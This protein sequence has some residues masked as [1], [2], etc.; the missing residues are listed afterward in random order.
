MINSR[1]GRFKDHH[2]DNNDSAG[3]VD[4]FCS[5]PLTDRQ[6]LEGPLWG[7]TVYLFLIGVWRSCR[8][9]RKTA[10]I[11]AAKKKGELVSY[12]TM[13]LDQRKLT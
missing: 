13:T 4:C 8:H 9:G 7:S 1:R 11:Q 5:S 3:T 12:T 10:R 6:V 2:Q